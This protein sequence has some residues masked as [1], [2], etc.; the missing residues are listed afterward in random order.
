MSESERGTATARR[1]AEQ[2]NGLELAVLVPLENPRGDAVEHIR[3]WTHDQTLGRDRYQVILGSSGDPLDLERRA[4]ELLAPQDEMIRVPG[5]SLIGLYDAA[6]RAARAPVLV[7]TEAHCRAERGCLLALAE[8]FARD[9]ELD[10]VT[11]AYRQTYSTAVG[12]LSVRRLEEVLRKIERAG[13]TRLEVAGSAVRSKV[14]ERAGGLDPRLEI[15]AG[16]LLSARLQ[17]HGARTAHLKEAVVAHEL[18]DDMRETLELA[19]SYA[20]GE[21]LVRGEQDPEFCERY[22][23]PAEIWGRRLVYRPEVAGP[24]V[25]ALASAVRRSPRERWLARELAARLP[26]RV[27]GTRPRWAWEVATAQLH[28]AVAASGVAPAEARWH[29]YVSAQQRITRSVQLH[30]SAKQNGMAPSEAGVGVLGAERLDG[31][32]AGVHGLERQ[33]GRAFRWTEPVSLL[34][35]IPPANGAVLRLDTGGLRGRPLD[36]LHRI[37]AGGMQLPPDLISGDRETLEARLP[38]SFAQAIGREGVVLLCRPLIP[39]RTG[40]SD[41]RRLG[42]PIAEFELSAAHASG[43]GWRSIREG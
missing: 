6:A 11:C 9:P 24:I 8:A 21:C 28:R 32:I 10:A 25:A 23:G 42:M 43:T 39:S 12:E 15:F 31:V 41:R 1:E 20:R 3:T 38:P 27:A 5:A 35:L 22:F 40:S 2:G 18:Q 19:R 37:Y 33:G 4:A 17:D 34:R 29:S 7:L 13:R 16:A 26:A 30:E 14:Y 36:Y